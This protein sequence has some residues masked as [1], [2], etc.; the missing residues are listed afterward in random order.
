M[1]QILNRIAI[2][3]SHGLFFLGIIAWLYPFFGNLDKHIAHTLFCLIFMYISF[4]SSLV[5][6]CCRPC[7]AT[8]SLTKGI[9]AFLLCESSVPLLGR[10]FNTI[11]SDSLTAEHI[12]IIGSHM[13]GLSFLILGYVAYSLKKRSERANNAEAEKTC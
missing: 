2:L 3:S 11:F 8:A 7:F 6:A 9:L 5:I 10:L 13:A 4:L 1:R 12:L